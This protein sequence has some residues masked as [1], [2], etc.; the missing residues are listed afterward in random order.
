ML[1]VVKAVDG[2]FHGV[3]FIVKMFLFDLVDLV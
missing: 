2:A 3:D 1:P